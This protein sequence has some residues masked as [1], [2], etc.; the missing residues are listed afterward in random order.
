M[1]AVVQKIR[2]ERNLIVAYRIKMSARK[3][4]R[5]LALDCVLTV[6]AEPPPFL[7]FSYSQLQ[8]KEGATI[9]L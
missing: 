3:A 2:D 1:Q 5:L 8:K 6:G 9:K 7:S 4:S